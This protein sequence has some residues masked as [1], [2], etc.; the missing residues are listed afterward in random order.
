VAARLDELALPSHEAQQHV[1]Q[2]LPVDGVLRTSMGNFKS[3]KPK[4]ILR[5]ESGRNHGESQ[6]QLHYPISAMGRPPWCKGTA[7]LVGVLQS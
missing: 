2:T 7:C 1:E 4:S 3:R 6:V 5:A